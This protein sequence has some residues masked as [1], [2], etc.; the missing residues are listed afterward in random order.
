MNNDYDLYERINTIG[1]EYL[2]TQ[3]KSIKIK[4]INDEELTPEENECVED[5]ENE[6]YVKYTLAV[7]KYFIF[8]LQ[9]YN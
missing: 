8:E 1:K 7:L 5:W 4:M 9:G 3:L 6:N 2:N